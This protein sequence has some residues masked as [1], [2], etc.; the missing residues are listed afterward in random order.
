MPQD[1]SEDIYIENAAGERKRFD[2]MALMVAAASDYSGHKELKLGAAGPPSELAGA[3]GYIYRRGE[4]ALVLSKEELLRLVFWALRPAEYRALR[5][6]H[7]A[8]AEI[9]A[10][11]Y[12]PAEGRALQPKVK[13]PE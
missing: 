10:D 7:G 13:V 12:D 3:P 2:E 1:G 9:G 5:E 8:F 4:L 11:K 6:R